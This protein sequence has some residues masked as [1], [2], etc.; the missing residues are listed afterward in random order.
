MYQKRWYTDFSRH[1]LRFFCRYSNPDFRKD[2]DE[3]R[4]AACG[5]VIDSLNSEQAEIVKYLFAQKDH[6]DKNVE[7][8]AVEKGITT[9]EVYTVLFD[10]ERA[11]AKEMNLI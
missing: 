2:E 9:D 1:Y 11:V 10:V 8:C 4:Y 5:T 7:N 6:M 3:A